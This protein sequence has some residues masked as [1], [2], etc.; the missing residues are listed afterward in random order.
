MAKHREADIYRCGHCTHAFSDPAS[1]PRQ[2]SYD[3]AHYDDTHR[4]WFE[5]PNTALFDRLSFI[6]PKG[7]SVLDVGCGRGDYLRYLHR[8]RPDLQLTGIDYS[9]NEDEYIRF[10]QGEAL[11]L[12][13]GVWAVFAAGSVT[14]KTYLQTVICSPEATS[15]REIPNSSTVSGPAKGRTR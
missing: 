11:K 7:G 6:T 14:S 12:R 1:M 4:L 13:A 10:L 9:E 2:E 5:H 15:R 3:T 8:N